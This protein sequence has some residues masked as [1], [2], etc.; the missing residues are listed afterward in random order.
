MAGVGG[1]GLQVLLAEPVSDSHDEELHV[2]HGLQ[3]EGLAH[4]VQ[5]AALVVLVDDHHRY[6]LSLR[7]RPVLCLEARLSDV[8]HNGRWRLADGVHFVQ[9]VDH[10]VLIREVTDG[11]FRH[12]RAVFGRQPDPHMVVGRVQRRRHVAEELK[13]LDGVLGA[14]VGGPPEDDVDQVYVTTGHCKEERQS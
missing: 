9:L 2:L 10:L 14:T 7:S 12:G 5:D 1:H 13:R 6:F 8:P 3:Q 4:H 11:E